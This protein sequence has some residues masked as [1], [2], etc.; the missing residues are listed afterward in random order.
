MGAVVA[1]SRYL[2]ENGAELV[3]V[4]Y[5]PLPAVVDSEQAIAPDA[6]LVH[7]E[8]GSNQTLEVCGSGGDVDGAFRNAAHVVRERFRTNR[9]HAVPME[10]RATLA[11]ID[12]DG[13]ITLWTSSQMPHMVR[14]RVADLMRYPE[15][16][17]RVVS[18]DVGGG[19]GLKNYVI[20]EEVLACHF[21]RELGAPVKWIEDRREHLMNGYPSR[22]AI[23]DLEMAFAAD[24]T[25]LGARS[26]ILGDN[27]AYS[28]DPWPSAFEPL[29]IAL[30]RPGPYKLR[31]YAW[32]VRAACTNKSSI[33]TYRGVGLPGA[34]WM[35]E[36]MLDLAARDLGMDPA[37]IRRKNMI[38]PDEFPY[39]TVNGLE[40]DSGSSS[41][42]MDKALAMADYQSFRTRQTEARRQGRYLGIGIGNYVE[43]TTFGTRFIAPLGVQHGSYE[44]ASVRFDPNGGVELCVGTHSHG[45]GHH[46]TYAQLVA[47]QIGVDI[48]DISFVQGDTQGTPYGWGTLGGAAASSVAAARSSVPRA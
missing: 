29:Q 9:H 27:G 32:H 28:T 16:K 10:G 37:D 44:A 41:D 7:E 47:D 40:Y 14:T 34:A 19:F 43:M 6:A 30:A 26:D 35:H 42:A 20:A 31:N 24:G 1:E 38:R 5:E 3:E 2:A 8:F 18:P 22:D 11:A 17:I 21:A 39:Q 23:V 45:Q 48:S 12:P 46:T 15:Q 4:D 13:N 33:G 36:Q 25:L